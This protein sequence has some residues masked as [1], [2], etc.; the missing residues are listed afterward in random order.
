MPKE[1][2]NFLENPPEIRKAVYSLQSGKELCLAVAF[3]RPEWEQLLSDHQGPLRIICWLS[4]TNTN[5]R[6]VEN[7]MKRPNTNVK[8]RDSMH[9]KVYLAPKIGAVVGSANLSQAALSE[10]NIS[11]RT[12]RLF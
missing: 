9:C 7:L 1:A 3:V 6:A 10:E 8:Q 5:P 2:I 4:S 11:G 12:K